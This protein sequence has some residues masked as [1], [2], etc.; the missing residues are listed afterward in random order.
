M[1]EGAIWKHILL[2]ALPLLIGNL[3]QQLYNTVDSVILG[4][5]VGKDALAAIG[6]TQSICNTFVNFFNGLAL[7]AAVVVGQFFGANDQE[8]L[9]RAVGSTI[10]AAFLAGL[11][12]SVLSVPIA[13]WML[14][15]VKT[16]DDIFL[17]SASYLKL[18][19][20]GTVFL[21]IYNMGASILRATGNS[22]LPLYYLVITSFLNIILDLLFVAVFDMGVSGAA[23]ATV[24][25][26]AVSA[27]LV[28]IHLSRTHEVYRLDFRALYPE[29]GILK[30]I[31]FFGLPAGFQ[32]ALTA[33][34]NTFVQA[35]IN[36]FHD[37]A[38]MAGWACHLKIDQFGMLPAISICQA[39]TTFVSQNLGAKKPERAKKGTKTA[40]W[41]GILLLISVSSLSAL[42]APILIGWFNRDPAVIFYGV[43]FIRFMAPFRCF[44]ALTQGFSGALRG[45]GDS[46][47][48]M[49]IMLFAFVFCRQLY[50]FLATRISY[51]VHVVGFGYPIGW[52][53]SGLSMW[54]YYRKSVRTR[55]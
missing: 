34:S 20:T 35:Y 15:A 21:F 9:R 17:M 12:L 32:Q 54:I 8:N 47:G 25:S 29:S 39:T 51:T 46:K 52:M 5:F 26:E 53:I 18:Y 48:P 49:V 40:V 28:L 27:I 16:P 44:S 50:L 2:F 23:I 38:V 1:T 41:I 36:G 19:F 7:G 11:S 43:L 42:T 14:R 10:T 6:C 33:F 3:F 55:F 4:N 24:I 37:T 30:R 45:A 13:P 31:F 22:A